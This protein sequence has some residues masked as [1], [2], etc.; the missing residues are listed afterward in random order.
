M[1]IFHI[2]GRDST[3]FEN[4]CS[5]MFFIVQNPKSCKHR[6]IFTNFFRALLATVHCFNSYL[7]TV[8][9]LYYTF[10]QSLKLANFVS[11]MGANGEVC[12]KIIISAGI[13][14]QALH[15]LSL[16]CP[17]IQ[18]ST[19]GFLGSFCGP[20]EVLVFLYASVNLRVLRTKR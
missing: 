5:S 17:A 3:S 7:K 16:F 9:R 1:A 20:V 19:N 8:S 10:E 6:G 15:N 2:W 13:A 4:L 11:T 18:Q 12:L 14:M